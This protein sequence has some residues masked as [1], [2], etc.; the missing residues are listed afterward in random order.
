MRTSGTG[1]VLATLFMGVLVGIYLHYRQIHDLGLG[2]DAYLAAQAH[3][4][5]RI[6]QY[7]SAFTT[8]IAG[9]I[10]AVIGVAVYELIAAGFSKMAG[11]STAE[12]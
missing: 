4:F 10:L 3:R 7:H 11:P 5:D 8:I 2:R 6:M 9:V 1:R 12:E